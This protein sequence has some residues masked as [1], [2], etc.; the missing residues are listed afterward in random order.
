MQ[1][2]PELRALEGACAERMSPEHHGDAPRWLAALDALP[3]VG[4]SH[5]SLGDT[6]RIGLRSDMNDVQHDALAA[7]LR[8]LHPWRK[9][10]FEFF[11]LKIDTEWRSDWKWARLASALDDLAGKRIL[12]VG[13]GNGYYGWRM[14]ESGADFVLGVDP[15]ILFNMQHRAASFYLPELA[16]RNVLLPIQFEELPPGPVFDIVFSMGVIY[17]R[18]DPREHVARLRAHTAPGGRVFVETLV[19]G[20]EHS[21][22]L[23]PARRYAR[24]RNVWILP[25]VE[26]LQVWLAEAG[27]RDIGVV[28]VDRTTTEEQRTTDWMCFESLAAALD[29]HDPM[30]TVEGYPAPVRAVV[31]GRLKS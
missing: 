4:P 17:H 13:A 30:R 11:G 5:V 1:E 3:D 28:S 23:E 2:F 12:D 16:E 29:P 21:P 27:F 6:V 19:V 9:G 15:T 26:T 31:T 20:H 14:L 18:K 25:T 8:V 24:M 7:S 22:W 10:P